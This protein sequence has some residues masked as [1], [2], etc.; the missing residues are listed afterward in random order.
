L[1]VPLAT[2][3]G[4]N[5]RHPDQGAPG[6][7]MAM[8]G[9]PLPFAR[10]ATEGARTGDPRRAIEERYTGR[11]DYLARVRSDAQIMAAA[12]HL[13]A[14]DGDAV[15]GRARPLGALPAPARPGPRPPRPRRPIGA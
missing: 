15:V 7:F 12:G 2:F 8:M 9:S 1:R 5:P 6:D 10:T 4:W 11:D 3:T 14:E 13:L